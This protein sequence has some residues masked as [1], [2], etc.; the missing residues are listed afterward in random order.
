LGGNRAV[1][2]SGTY[3]DNSTLATALIV[4]VTTGAA[5]SGAVATVQTSGEMTEVSWTWDISKPVYLGSAGLLTQT[6]PAAG[7][8]VEIGKP[9]AATKLLIQIQPP[10]QLA[11]QGD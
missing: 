3:A 9:T 5:S 1:L 7:V 2:A 4:G 11:E 10:I 8:I 6:V